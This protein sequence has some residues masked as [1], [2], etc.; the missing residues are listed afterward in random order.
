MQECH[1]DMGAKT[2]IPSP[3]LRS[4]GAIIGRGY[5]TKGSNRFSCERATLDIL[6]KKGGYYILCISACDVHAIGRLDLTIK[7]G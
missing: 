5:G 4:L 3:R 2:T 6:P 7:S 1:V